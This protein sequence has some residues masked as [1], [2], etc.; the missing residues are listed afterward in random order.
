MIMNQSN[1]WGIDYMYCMGSSDWMTYKMVM[2]Q[3]TGDY[4]QDNMVGSGVTY[5]IV[6]NIPKVSRNLSV[7]NLY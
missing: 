6:S 3:W 5:E 2:Y 4:L 7:L 1:A